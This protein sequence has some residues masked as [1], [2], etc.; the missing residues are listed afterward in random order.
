MGDHCR[1]LNPLV[2]RVPQEI[3]NVGTLA[4]TGERDKLLADTAENAACRF[5]RSPAVRKV[6][7]HRGPGRKTRIPAAQRSEPVRIG[8]RW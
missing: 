3:G 7:V 1:T 4:L 6:P 5:A 8:K 2:G